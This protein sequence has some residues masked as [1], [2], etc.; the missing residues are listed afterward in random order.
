M[1]LGYFSMYKLNCHICLSCERERELYVH[2]DSASGYFNSS[3]YKNRLKLIRQNGVLSS[4]VLSSPSLSKVTSTA[5]TVSTLVLGRYFIQA[6]C[7]MVK[8]G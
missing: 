8:C 1:S 7:I 2:V 5:T 3:I 6:G 4:K